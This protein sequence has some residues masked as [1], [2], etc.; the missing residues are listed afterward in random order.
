ML[1]VFSDIEFKGKT[2][3]LSYKHNYNWDEKRNRPK[4]V[5][6]RSVSAGVG[7]FFSAKMHAKVRFHSIKNAEI[8]TDVTLNGKV[9]VEVQLK[10]SKY[11]KVSELPLMPDLDVPVPGFGIA[12]KFRGLRFEFGLFFTFGVILKDIEKCLQVDIDYF[13]GYEFTAKRYICIKRHGTTDSG[14]TTQ[15]SSIPAGNA[16]EGT[17]TDLESNF[18]RGTI[19]FNQGIKLKA[20]VAV[21]ET[22]LSFGLAEPFKIE[23]GFAPLACPYPYMYGG[24]EMPLQSYYGFDGVKIRIKLFGKRIKCT[25]LHSHYKYHH[26]TQLIKTKR[27][28]LF[29]SQNNNDY[30]GSEID[31]EEDDDD[32]YINETSYKILSLDAYDLENKYKT[33]TRIRTQLS[34][35]ERNSTENEQ[36]QLVSRRATPFEDLT[37]NNYFGASIV[38]VNQSR[39]NSKVTLNFWYYAGTNLAK[40]S[41]DYSFLLKEYI[42]KDDGFIPIYAH[43]SQKTEGV[44]IKLRIKYCEPLPINEMYIPSFRLGVIDTTLDFGDK[45]CV[46]VKDLVENS[47]DYVDELYIQIS[48]QMEPY[49]SH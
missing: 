21:I 25:I 17:A 23:F 33:H 22:S 4:L 38:A 41:D 35:S 18:I 39:L 3:L 47:T 13:K 40:K 15:F 11:E 49:L 46:I 42:R 45:L 27:Y 2:P 20:V 8:I 34:L 12:F 16:V 28:C 24:F 36:F 48:Q 29:D 14:W 37:N 26:I 44:G 30:I 32:Q 19:Q 31:G 1:F 9:G 10:R 43:N 5:S 7:T 6:V